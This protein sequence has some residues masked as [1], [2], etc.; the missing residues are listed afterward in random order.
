MSA[1]VWSI[2]GMGIVILIAIAT[3]NRALRKEMTERF[4]ELGRR[5]DAVSER[6]NV[7]THEL[8]GRINELGERINGRINELSEHLNGRINGLGEQVNGRINELS[9]HL[10]GR[11]GAVE[12]RLL[13]R[14]SDVR[15]RLARVEGLLEGL[16]TAGRTRP[17]RSSDDVQGSQRTT[18]LS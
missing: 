4:E 3:S 1:E 13:E 2:I 15:T 12:N 11:I 10:N 14:L 6:L 8:D 7:R 17:A 18:G 9:E 16:W 5:I